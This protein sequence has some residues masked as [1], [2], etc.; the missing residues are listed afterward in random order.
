MKLED[1]EKIK[2]AFPI[3]RF[4]V[5]LFLLPALC[6]FAIV[7]DYVL[8]GVLLVVGLGCQIGF[9]TGALKAFSSIALALFA[10]FV[11]PQYAYLVEP[12]LNEFY[13]LTGL[14]NRLVSI[15]VI[16]FGFGI[17]LA[18]AGAFLTWMFLEKESGLDRGNRVFGMLI[19][20]A[21]CAI[22]AVLLL[23]GIQVIA[24]GFDQ[25]SL[26][27][28]SNRF[29]TPSDIA[30]VTVAN[31]AKK[32]QSSLIGPILEKHNPFTRYPEYNPLPKVEQTVQLLNDPN[33]IKE[34]LNDESTS[35]K[36]QASPEFVNAIERLSVEPEIQKI[37]SSHEPPSLQQVFDLMNSQ[38][39][40]EILDEPGVMEEATRLL[41]DSSP[42]GPE[43]AETSLPMPQR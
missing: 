8:A 33:L 9:R 30:F 43:F 25:A 7:E 21:E 28:A 12:K 17:L 10:I 6:A 41:K 37:L 20:G 18:A 29:E 1:E 42:V 36:I 39:I 34:F 16:S 15:T 38:S 24:P 11:A 23:G 32:T 3:N 2:K 14:T 31:V 40:L 13:G 22:A 27:E 26:K 35:E 5:V 4:C 19:G